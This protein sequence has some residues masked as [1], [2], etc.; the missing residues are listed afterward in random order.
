MITSAQA[1]HL[2]SLI[3]HAGGP[4][5]PRLL[6]EVF[7]RSLDC[8]TVLV[9]GQELTA[10]VSIECSKEEQAQAW[11]I[12]Q[13]ALVLEKG[14]SAT[15]CLQLINCFAEGQSI[16]LSEEVGHEFIV[17]AHWFTR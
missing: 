1:R 12:S 5:F 8:N 14:I 16:R 11:A 3:R 9:N 6:M 17:R 4:R 13:E 7:R 2:S 15:L 10:L